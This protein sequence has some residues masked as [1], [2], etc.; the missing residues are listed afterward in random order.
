MLEETIPVK[1]G[2]G[3]CGRGGL[4]LRD[5]TESPSCLYPA[6]RDESC[7]VWTCGRSGQGALEQCIEPSMRAGGWFC[8]PWSIGG[9]NGPD[10]K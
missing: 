5:G 7:A 6:D 4:L 10:S 1:V 8:G 9:N 3:I 2:V